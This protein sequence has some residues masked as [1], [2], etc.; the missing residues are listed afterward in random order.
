MTIYSVA[1]I[2]CDGIGGPVTEAAFANPDVDEYLEANRIKYAIRLPANR[3]LQDRIGCLLKCPVGATT[4]LCSAVPRQLPLSGCE[5]D[6]APRGDC[7]G[8]M[9]SG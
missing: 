2:P 6:H 8:G 3:V 7:Q 9:A 1:L 5:V 4:E